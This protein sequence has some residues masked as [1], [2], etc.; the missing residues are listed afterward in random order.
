MHPVKRNGRYFSYLLRLWE[1]TDGD[2]VVWLAML[3]LPVTGEKYSF[4]SLDDLFFYLLG[5]TYSNSSEQFPGSSP[6]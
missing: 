2:Q 6:K 3:E 5:K 4:T 1:T